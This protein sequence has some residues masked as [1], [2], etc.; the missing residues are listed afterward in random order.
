[1]SRHDPSAAWRVL[2]C[3]KHPVSARLH[4]LVPQSRGV[5][6]PDPLPALS[7]VSESEQSPAVQSHPAMALRELEQALKVKAGLQWVDEFRL[8]LE[9]PG[10]FLSVYLA[11]LSGHDL[12][13]PPAGTRWIQLSESIGMPW[14][15]REILRRAY[16]VLIG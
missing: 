4:F 2:L 15:D 7:V 11:A 1:M 3:H 9:A 6:L 14:L 5:L 13:E 16:G 12:I 8:H 10:M